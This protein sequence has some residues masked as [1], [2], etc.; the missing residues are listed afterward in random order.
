M[1]CTAKAQVQPPKLN[2]LNLYLWKLF[3]MWNAILSFTGSRGNILPLWP[4]GT[5]FELPQ[6]LLFQGSVSCIHLKPQL[7]PRV[8]RLKGYPGD[9]S[10][11]LYWAAPARPLLHIFSSSPLPIFSVSRDMRSFYS[12]PNIQKC[13]H[14]CQALTKLPW[15]QCMVLPLLWVCH[16]S[17][18][19]LVRQDVLT[20]SRDLPGQW[21][22]S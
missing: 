19:Q 6:F 10:Q 14:F 12:F 2:L 4:D 21:I 7:C 15:T 22:L 20:A 8:G 17:R 13:H 16:A 11:V 3:L 9:L 5:L 18:C 1:A